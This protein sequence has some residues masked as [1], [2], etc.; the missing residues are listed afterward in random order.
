M[1]IQDRVPGEIN[2]TDI[3]VPTS[4]LREGGISQEPWTI[5][6]TS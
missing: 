5:A 4:C 1:V 6:Q 3:L 2:G